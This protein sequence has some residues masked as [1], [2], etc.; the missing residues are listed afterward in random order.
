MEVSVMHTYSK[1]AVGGAMRL[2]AAVAI[3][4]LAHNRASAQ[5]TLTLQLRNPMPAQLSAWE[6]DPTILQ[7]IIVNGGSS[8]YGD[9]RFSFVITDLGSGL[10]AARSEND[11]P[12]IPRFTIPANATVALNGPDVINLGAVAVD[13]RL[14]DI[15][16]TTNALPEGDYEICAL[17]LDDGGNNLLS[18]ANVCRVF[19][20]VIPDPPVLITPANNSAGPEFVRP[21]FSWTPVSIPGIAIEYR[22]L[23][24]PVYA[25]QSVRDAIERNIPLLDERLGFASYLY[26]LRDPA[27]TD[28]VD[29]LG[30]AWQVQ[31]LDDFGNPAT[32]NDG[33]SEIFSFSIAEPRISIT[34]S[35]TRIDP[36]GENPS[37]P[38]TFTIR[39]PAGMPGISLSRFQTTIAD[40]DPARNWFENSGDI[41]ID[42]PVYVPPGG[43]E[44]WTRTDSYDAQLRSILL[45]GREQADYRKIFRFSGINDVGI[46][47]GPLDAQP[48]FIHLAGGEFAATFSPAVLNFTPHSTS[49]QGRFDFS[50]SSIGDISLHRNEATWFLEDGRT[51]DVG[52]TDM[53]IT[54]PR[55]GSTF[56][57]PTLALDVGI[58]CGELDRLG[59]DQTE[60]R[61][62]YQFDGDLHVQGNPDQ[63]V[64]AVASFFIRLSRPAG[65][66]LTVTATP[67]VL[68]YTPADLRQ[69][70]SLRYEASCFPLTL[71]KNYA[72]LRRSD[73]RESQIEESPMDLTV[74]SGGSVE[75]NLAQP[76][77]RDFLCQTLDALGVDET[78]IQVTY[79]FVYDVDRPNQQPLR[80]TTETQFVMHLMRPSS[81]LQLSAT[82]DPTMIYY[83]QGQTEQMVRFLLLAGGRPVHVNRYDAVWFT[84]DNQRL[85]VE[86]TGWDTILTPCDPV[87]LDLWGSMSAEVQ[88]QN[89]DRFQVP[90]LD[91]E[92]IYYFRGTIE[93][94]G[95]QLEDVVAEAR[96]IMR[97]SGEGGLLTI[98]GAPTTPLRFYPGAPV[99]QLTYAAT[100]SARA[101]GP[102]EFSWLAAT[103]TDRD[104]GTTVAVMYPEA[105]E[106]NEVIRIPPGQTWDYPWEEAFSEE[107][108]LQFLDGR[109]RRTVYLTMS[110]DADIAGENL[111][112]TS[113]AIEINLFASEEEAQAL[114]L[115]V[116]AIPH[117]VDFSPEDTT[118]TIT[119]N[120]DLYPSSSDSITLF[121][122]GIT[123]RDQDGTV[124]RGPI[125]SQLQN[126]IRMRPGEQREITGLLTVTGADRNDILSGGRESRTLTATVEFGGLTDAGREI[127]SAANPITMQVFRTAESAGRQRYSLI[128]GAAY[129]RTN[130]RTV[131]VTEG[132][133]TI[134]NGQAYLIIFVEPFDSN[135]YVEV[136]LVNLTFQ[137]AQHSINSGSLFVESTPDVP[138][139][140]VLG[141]IYKITH[142]S[143]DHTRQE[144][145]RLTADEGYVNFL[146]SRMDISDV[147]IN[148]DG[149]S[150]RNANIEYPMF[151]LMFRFTELRNGKEGDRRMLSFAVHTRLKGRPREDEFSRSTLK[152]FEGGDFA[153]HFTPTPK[154]R[155]ISEYLSFTDFE[156]EKN[157]STW[158]LKVT[159]EINYPAPFKSLGP[160]EA[161]L[162]YNQ[163]GDLTGE[164]APIIE[165]EGG[166][167]LVGD[168]DRSWT[169]IGDFAVADLTYLGV[170]IAVI[171]GEIDNE[172]SR[173]GL[174]ASFYF[175]DGSRDWHRVEV[176]N[177]EAPGITIDF[178]GEVHWRAITV[179]HDKKFKLGPMVLGIQ[180]LVVNPQPTDQLPHFFEL[181]GGIG[182]D[183][184]TVEGMINFES[185]R[186]KE[187]GDIDMASTVVRGGEFRIVDV[188]GLGIGDFDFSS[189]PTTL[190]YKTKDG[191]R[192]VDRSVEVNSYFKLTGASLSIGAAGRGGSGGFKQLL[193]YTADG[194]TSFILDSANTE[195]AEV[196]VW[197]DCRHIQDS[198][199]SV[200]SVAGGVDT[201]GGI[202]GAIVGKIGE[203]NGD[204]TYGLFLAIGGLNIPI[205]P[206]TLTELG[207]GFFYN[208]SEGDLELVRNSVGISRKLLD[209]LTTSRRPNGGGDAGGFAAMIYAAA[210]VVDEDIIKGKAL[211]TVTEN[212]LSLDINAELL[213]K[214]GKGWA[215]M[216]FSWDPS[217]AEGLV[218]AKFDYE[219]LIEADAG[220]DF[221]AYS[222]EVWGVSGTVDVSILSLVEVESDF[223]VGAPGFMV[224]SE[225][226][227]G[228]DAGF[229][230]AEAGFETMIWWRKNVS[231]GGYANVH[232]EG[233][234][235]WGLAGFSAG[236]EGALIGSPGILYCVG[237]VRAE[238][239]W[240]EVFDGSVWV[241]VSKNGI[242]AGEGRNE[243]YDAMIADA[244]RMGEQMQDEMSNL[245]SALSDARNALGDL[246]DEQRAHAGRTLLETATGRFVVVLGYG[247]ELGVDNPGQMQWMY[248]N[249][250]N[251]AAVRRIQ[252]R[253]NELENQLD[254]INTLLTDLESR[255][256]DV[257][258]HLRSR[259]GVFETTL[260]RITDLSS[261]G[262]PVG[263][264]SYGTVTIGGRTITRQ[265]GYGFD[266]LRADNM[267]TGFLQQK[268]SIR[269]YQQRLIDLAEEYSHVI[270][271]IDSILHLGISSLSGLTT[272]YVNVFDRIN[273]Y[274]GDVME[275]LSDS[276]ATAIE[277]SSAMENR[278]Q[279]ILD[280]VSAQSGLIPIFKVRQIVPLRR[281]IIQTLVSNWNAPPDPLNDQQWRDQC[282]DFGIESWYNIPHA[283]FDAIEE[284]TASAR[285]TVAQGMG[286]SISSFGTRWV[287]FTTSIDGVYE[288][289]ASLNE[290]LFDLYD[291][292]ALSASALP[293][294]RRGGVPPGGGIPGIGGGGGN[295]GIVLEE[296]PRQYFTG[297]RDRIGRALEP[298]QITSFSGTATSGIV[299]LSTMNLSWAADH[300][301]R[302][303]EFS[304]RISQPIQQPIIIVGG[305]PGPQFR[306]V[307]TRGRTKLSLVDDAF[308]EGTYVVRLKARGAG[309]YAIER[310][311]T[312]SVEFL[313]EGENGPLTGT[314]NNEDNTAPTTPV[315]TDD[316]SFTGSSSMLHGSWHS[317]D[318]QSGIQEYQY[319]VGRVVKVSDPRIP[320][321]TVDRLVRNNVKE[322]TPC[323]AMEE[324]NIRQLL[325]E[326]GKTY[327]ISVQ[328]KNG[329]GLWSTIGE[330]DGITADLTPPSS[331][332]FSYFRQRSRL[333][334]DGNL[335]PNSLLAAWSASRDNESGLDGYRYSIGTSIG[336]SDIVSGQ[337]NVTA[338][339]HGS[340]PLEHDHIYFMRVWSYNNTGS[341]SQDDTASARV[342]FFDNSAPPEGPSFSSVTYKGD[343]LR[344]SWTLS[345]EDPESGTL[346]YEYQVTAIVNGIQSVL[347]PW[348]SV[349]RNA[350][351]GRK[352]NLKFALNT[353]NYLKVRVVNGVGLSTTSTR[354][355]TR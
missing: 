270:D 87:V 183:H 310:R 340:L 306:S 147:I 194:Q 29:A 225:V 192:A 77:S 2:I 242:D 3:L 293:T 338:V 289:K 132:D 322:W 250:L 307:G 233:E 51:L 300:P 66:P 86:P 257:D 311:G 256:Q 145:S 18:V 136:D 148:R 69:M 158:F 177:F 330:S 296:S 130:S 80:D 286:P 116:F 119:Y 191:G 234:I 321:R 95:G 37:H 333:G 98:V 267:K 38:I 112:A 113:N 292:L 196:K 254:G 143:Y 222:S 262:S 334:G 19:R 215:F 90:V 231:W 131:V 354:Q 178:N 24:C 345:E 5:V 291:Q 14:R 214:A 349:G 346:R 22:L 259:R 224:S 115:I 326:H 235:L 33:K 104:D 65:G 290:L 172:Q 83:N 110:I 319:A 124:Y 149:L 103:Y 244:R 344:A 163:N 128:E 58:I 78:D 49:Q 275:Y 165:R 318:S 337:T 74:P 170:Q 154:L 252:D 43:E 339:A 126:P 105:G 89:L 81:N 16:I 264:M 164:L 219:G 121:S 68:E 21:V 157:D 62:V 101:E 351:M 282:R 23:L 59:R 274:Y 91:I 141:G 153:G 166:K 271:Q 4:F 260:P 169:S 342:S 211:I 162:K 255:R 114:E 36:T 278:R 299:A 159:T 230:K 343:S 142:I 176:G 285:R 295:G 127:R 9:C 15:A 94:V 207:G 179:A 71:V 328:A 316:G 314:L 216:M 228:F 248:D 156:F 269:E 243:E 138:L 146:R 347:V 171:D 180:N 193:V 237:T 272:D 350:N 48:Y 44:T 181:A 107:R 348:T 12:S 268:E 284:G 199:G 28:V 218:K 117:E 173:V 308:P 47:V 39:V 97:I 54:I 25:G 55:S 197:V 160:T 88:R 187:N 109:R 276:R 188:V 137:G 185:L 352:V 174:A 273:T 297:Q 251:T 336:D 85:A 186:I 34:V 92:V 298:P 317:T 26:S 204:A 189:T 100:L 203:V 168:G 206:V 341:P 355:I 195:I 217:Y 45:D 323:G 304:Y 41:V 133:R 135:Q 151:G 201:P 303:A 31:A 67:S 261:Y 96:Y 249:V 279:R 200:L 76:L 241:A 313:E 73:G 329:V 245:A 305:S 57:E 70:L 122:T 50:G 209:S 239:L 301:V 227:V 1:H 60:I 332:N 106:G 220:I 309:G 108:L 64:S 40:E 287:N 324:L 302:V 229:L 111:T 93:N 247:T 232:A 99:Q 35:P 280:A 7:A 120:L 184:E 182:V 150:L 139:M 312:M 327:Y 46:P 61:V 283:G 125:E 190:T 155:L 320:G 294:I 118:H 52:A 129:I 84:P 208:P 331:P 140:S 63:P 30:F 236:L 144:G 240:T 335:P 325:L 13:N 32:R 258:E 102:A 79:F 8:S 221:Y 134:L 246:S 253:R 277:K 226:E 175:N 72:R 75:Q 27:L 238:V 11:D 212:Y 123:Y 263:S 265:T 266:A 223:F 281:S 17:L 202:D 161:S 213:K 42:P 6:H 288:R 353:R 210:K 205:G 56:Y 53:D 10:E 20:V 82:V 167:P 152:Y 315:V 198:S